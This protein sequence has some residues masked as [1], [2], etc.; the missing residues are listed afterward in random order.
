MCVL[1]LCMSL[2]HSQ[3]AIYMFL[4]MVQIEERKNIPMSFIVTN[5]P[6]PNIHILFLPFFS[7]PAPKNLTLCV[8]MF[9]FFSLQTI[10]M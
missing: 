10:E 7:P 2:I 6:H 3:S 5:P 8:F 4:C 9:P 1:V